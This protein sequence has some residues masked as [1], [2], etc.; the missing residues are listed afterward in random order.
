MPPRY[1]SDLTPGSGRRR[2][3]CKTQRRIIR[4]AGGREGGR[5]REGIGK[6]PQLGRLTQLVYMVG[7]FL[8]LIKAHGKWRR[9]DSP[10]TGIDP[11]NKITNNEFMNEGHSNS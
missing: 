11:L 3:L 8:L 10:K 1:R 7:S 4:P 2:M 6:F 9:D 5:G